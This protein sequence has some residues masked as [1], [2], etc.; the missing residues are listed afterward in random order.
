MINRSFGSL[1]AGEFKDWFDL[2]AA[3]ILKEMLRHINVLSGMWKTYT[4][5][6]TID[7]S[8]IHI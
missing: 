6:A 7:L 5:S 2:V 4:A 3:A 1:V 8:L